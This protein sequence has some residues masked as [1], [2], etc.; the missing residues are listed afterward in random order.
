MRP[1]R[2]PEYCRGNAVNQLV[3]V[4]RLDVIE[5]S[6]AGCKGERRSRV[7]GYAGRASRGGNSSVGGEKSLWI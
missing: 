2:L 4:W 3:D 5:R 6:R 1:F 7:R